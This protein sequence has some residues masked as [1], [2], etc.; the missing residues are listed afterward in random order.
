MP[1]TIVD[2]LHNLH[3]TVPGSHISA[4][5]VLWAGLAAGVVFLALEMILM[6]LVM[7]VSVW[8]PL[9]M[10]AAITMGSAVLSPPDTFDS[11]AVSAA[12]VIHFALSLV[13]ALVFAFI[14]K[15][16]S[17]RADALFGAAFGLLL[18]LVNFYVFTL[19]FPWFAE[20]RN[21]AT[22]LAHLAFGAVLGATYAFWAKR[23]PAK[24]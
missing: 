14:G 16:R 13:Y 11:G 5:A 9:R 8:V 1:A 22:I 2:R 17:V 20:A 24:S 4:K 21:W 10:I 18:Y 23:T 19:Q 7:G 15:G 12:V 6:P 3:F